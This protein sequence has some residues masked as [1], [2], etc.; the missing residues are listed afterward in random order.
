[1]ER[2]RSRFDWIQF[3]LLLLA[4][5]GVAVHNEGRLARIEQRQIDADEQRK[6]LAQQ[7][8][9]FEDKWDRSPTLSNPSPMAR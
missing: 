2:E 5:I 1:M 4:I 7:L 3:A 8:Q 6:E 9:R